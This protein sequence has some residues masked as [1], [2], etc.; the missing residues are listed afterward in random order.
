MMQISF[1]NEPFNDLVRDGTAGKTMQKLLEATKPQAAYFCEV[2]GKRTGFLI[3]DLKEPSQIPAFCE[4]W[5]LALKAEI[6]LRPTMTPEDLA[7]SGIDQLG[8]GW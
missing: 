8:K 2:D 3:V 4:P 6:R 1:P 5:F 7:K